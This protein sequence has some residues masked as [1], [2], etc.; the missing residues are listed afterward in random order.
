M[1]ETDREMQIL[2]RGLQFS[3]FDLNRNQQATISERQRVRLKTIQNASYHTIIAIGSGAV[4]VLFTVAVILLLLSDSLTAEDL[5]IPIII[6]VIVTTPCLSV[7]LYYIQK[8]RQPLH[9][10]VFRASGPVQHIQQHTGGQYSTSIMQIRVGRA[11]LDL[12]DTAIRTFA[13]GEL[14]T[15]YFSDKPRMILSA[16]PGDTTKRKNRPT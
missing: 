12:P 16:E 1:T 13:E 14:Y 3:E 9:T 8:L 10:R 2:M 11:T 4:V 7:V 15:V 6:L 5:I